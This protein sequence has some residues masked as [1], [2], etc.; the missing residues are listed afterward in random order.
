MEKVKNE[1]W[2]EISML[3]CDI[4]NLEGLSELLEDY[5]C[6]CGGDRNFQKNQCLAITLA[7]NIKELNERTRNLYKIYKGLTTG[8]D[9]E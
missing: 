7:K 6:S 2:N 3:E 9:Y 8:D 4:A 1:F 5:F